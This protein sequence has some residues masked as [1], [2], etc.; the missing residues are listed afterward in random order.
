MKIRWL[1][2]AGFKISF[3]DPSD[4]AITRNI[5][6]DTWLDGPTFPSDAKDEMND[7]DL[8]LVTHGHFDHS[9]GAPVVYNNSKENGKDPKI[10]V[11]FELANYFIKHHSVPEEGTT[12]MNKGCP[13]DFGFCTIIMV[14]ADHSSG[15]PGKDGEM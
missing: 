15:C 8:I 12:R 6:I 13:L 3:P 7:A 10:V 1:G 4:S 5:F 11:I 14:G 2:H 9:A